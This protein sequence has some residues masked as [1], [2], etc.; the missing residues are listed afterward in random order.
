MGCRPRDDTKASLFLFQ[1]W[2][3][4]C[5]HRVVLKFNE[6]HILMEASHG[7]LYVPVHMHLPSYACDMRRARRGLLWRIGAGLP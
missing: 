3:A 1:H 2:R 4:Q 5:V 7:L 6:M